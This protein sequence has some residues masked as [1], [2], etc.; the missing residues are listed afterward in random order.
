MIVFVCYDDA[1]YMGCSPP[2]KVFL[3]EGAA[4]RYSN[5]FRWGTYKEL[6]VTMNE[7]VTAA[8]SE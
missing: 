1:N 7:E 3:D 6:E 8:R 4:I 2:E 5:R